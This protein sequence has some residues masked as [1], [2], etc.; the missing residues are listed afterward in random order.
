M[1]PGWIESRGKRVSP[2]TLPASAPMPSLPTRIV[3][4]L[5]PLTGNKRLLASEASLRA[6]LPRLRR[7]GPALPS[8]RMR[9]RFHVQER[10][11]HGARTFTVAPRSNA[12]ASHILYLHGG[13]YYADILPS[14]WWF[15]GRL[16]QR[17]GASVTVP[18]YPLAP[19]HTVLDVLDVTLP[20]ARALTAEVGQANLTM[21]GESAGG[22]LA[23][24]LAEQLRDEK[25]PL[26]RRL[27]LIAPWLDLT[28]SDPRQPQ[29]AAEDPLLDLPGARAAGRMYAG[30]VPPT[31]PKVSPLFGT[32]HGLPP[33]SVFTGTHDL[34]NADACRLAEKAADEGLW[35]EF[36]EYGG[37]F[38][39]FVLAPIPEATQALDE[40][41]QFIGPQN[42]GPPQEVLATRRSL[43]MT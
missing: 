34:V 21:M 33:T 24:A 7:R 32:L 11:I 22:G 18:L 10:V 43:P 5:L 37:L 3:E 15:I 1:T 20:L 13:G 41:A 23:L 31:D 19:E 36:H 16:V 29:L 4:W 39:A 8:R 40:I 25:L 42:M 28:L 2:G 30:K 26:P 38:H 17:T 9:R 14:H 35:L 27:V 6:A 12:T